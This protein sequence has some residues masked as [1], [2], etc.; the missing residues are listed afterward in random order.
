MT[1]TKFDEIVKNKAN[2]NVQAR[3]RQFDKDIKEAIAKLYPSHRIYSDPLLPLASDN[4]SIEYKETTEDNKILI[5]YLTT[6]YSKLPAKIW[7]HE[8]EL[9]AKQLLAQLDVVAS[10]LVSKK[11]S[12]EDIAPQKTIYDT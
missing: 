9:V 4:A 8:E 3:I 5:Q 6:K 1:P 2:E 7:R 12:D 11:P 10:A